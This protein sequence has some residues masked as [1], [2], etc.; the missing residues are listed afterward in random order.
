MNDFEMLNPTMRRIR[1]ASLGIGAVAMLLC[2]GGA[3][4]DSGQFFH[5]YLVGFLF[6]LGV[7]LGCAAILMLHHLVGGGWGLITRRLLESGTRTTP[8]MALLMIPLFYGLPRLYNWTHTAPANPGSLLRFKNVYLQTPFFEVRA[9]LYFAIWLV[10]VYFLNKWSIEQDETGEPAVLRRLRALSGPGIVIYCLTATFAAVDWVMS[11]APE[12]YSTAYGLLFIV[13][14]VLTAFSFIIGVA[15]LLANRSSLSRVITRQ[16]LID[17][18]NLILTFV[19]LWAYI[20]FTQFLII[21]AGN[22]PE[23]ISWYMIHIKGGWLAIVI[24][25]MV[26]HFALPFTLLLFRDIKRNANTLAVVAGAMFVVR[27]ADIWWTV[28][29]TWHPT[30]QL[31]WMDILAPV[32]IGGIWIFVFVWQLQRRPLLPL[33]PGLEGLS[34]KPEGAQS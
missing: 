10:F 4:S 31:H 1:I 19:M 28:E 7:A 26:F 6:W 2:I 13:S 15:M 34:Y 27:L 5:S 16:R 30:I 22:L 8:L 12:W 29:P 21:W 25:L 20:A 14:E 24:A 17:L 32:G 23:E 3:F 9:V 33:N 11:L 18:G